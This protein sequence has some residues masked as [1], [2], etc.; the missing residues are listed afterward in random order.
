MY[1]FLASRLPAPLVHA[2]Y[3]VWYTFLLVLV[4]YLFDRGALNFY[5]LHR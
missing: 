2:L 1:Q 5:Y 3:A 4:Y